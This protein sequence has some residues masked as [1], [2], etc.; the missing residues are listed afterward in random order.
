MRILDAAEELFAD[1]GFAPTS[2][3]NITAEAG[4]NLAAVHYHFG[5]KEAL[6]SDVF[7]RRV[8]PINGE[9]LERL[10][11]LRSGAE[12]PTVEQIVE[13]FVEPPLR[14]SHEWRSGATVMRMLGHAMSQPD[15]KEI[16]VAQ[17]R[18]TFHRFASALAD[19]LPEL[20]ER[21]ILWRFLFMVGSMGQG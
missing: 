11:R 8:A 17:F 4:V 10:E 21:E 2:L 16:F 13:A 18:E 1:N 9:R 3:L 6:I 5:S 7:S 20:P 12:P 15:V 14:L 19:V